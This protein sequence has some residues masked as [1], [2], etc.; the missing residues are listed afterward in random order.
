MFALPAILSQNSGLRYCPLNI[1]DFYNINNPFTAKQSFIK[2]CPLNTG[3]FNNINVTQEGSWNPS[4]LSPSLWLDGNDLSTV[5]EVNGFVSSWNDKS[6]NG[7]HFSQA[8]VANRPVKGELIPNLNFKHHISF[9]TS[10]KRLL[11]NSWSFTLTSQHTFV[12]FIRSSGD[13]IFSQSNGGVDTGT[14]MYLPVS[15]PSTS[16]VGSYL[17]STTL[18]GSVSFNTANLRANMFESRHN[19][20]SLFNRVNGGN[21]VSFTNALNSTVTRSGINASLNASSGVGNGGVIRVGEI[22][23]FNNVSLSVTDIE[24]V[25][26]YLAWKWGLVNDLP[27]AHPFKA[28][29]PNI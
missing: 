5:T 21:E 25:Q 7:N 9:D 23:V 13:K 10:D 6:G 12:V 20:S 28:N 19:G 2:Y 15:S 17:G 29:A 22:L 27:L 1:N 24:R 16:T 8:T 18:R 4:F 14:G 3:G 11:N 26:G